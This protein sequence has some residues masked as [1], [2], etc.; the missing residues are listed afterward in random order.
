MADPCSCYC[1]PPIVT[2]MTSTGC[3]VFG[4]QFA[5]IPFVATAEKYRRKGHARRLISVSILS[6]QSSARACSRRQ[7]A[8]LSPSSNQRAL[9]CLSACQPAL[10]RT[11]LPACLPAYLPAPSLPPTHLHISIISRQILLRPGHLSLNA[12]PPPHPTPPPHNF[13]RLILQTT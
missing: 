1:L 13:K 4:T 11:A 10:Q 12:P 6:A 3:R 9:V 5:E 7:P 8:A 2:E